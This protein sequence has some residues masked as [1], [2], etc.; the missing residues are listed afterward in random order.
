MKDINADKMLVKRGHLK[1]ADIS[2]KVIPGIKKTLFGFLN[3]VE[4][5]GRHVQ[6]GERPNKW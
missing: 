3:R 6:E 5:M 4:Q 2:K 1:T